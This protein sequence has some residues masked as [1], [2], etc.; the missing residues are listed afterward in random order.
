MGLCGWTADNDSTNFKMRL[1]AIL[2]QGANYYAVGSD[3]N[4]VVNRGPRDSMARESTSASVSPHGD[5]RDD[6]KEP[7]KTFLSPRNDR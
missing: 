2:R 7:T 4:Y 6:D 3:R 5:G 1:S